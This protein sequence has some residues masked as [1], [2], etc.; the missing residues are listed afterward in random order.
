MNGCTK[1]LST[2]FAL[3]MIMTAVVLPAG[4]DSA[5]ALLIYWRG[6]TPCEKALKSGLKD[7][8][9]NIQLSEFD[10]QQDKGFWRQSMDRRQSIFC[11]YNVSDQP[12]SL[13]ITDLNLIITDRWWDL[14]SGHI[15]DEN[16]ESIS[17]SPYQVLWITNI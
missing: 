14:I 17:L 8:G 9:V 16:T 12:Q 5:K 7:L 11:I 15:F 4:A 6:E 1:V 13:H 10:A 2:V 3:L